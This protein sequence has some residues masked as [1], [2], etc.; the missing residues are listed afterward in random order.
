MTSP[1]S[2]K[3]R[4]FQYISQ[5][6][7]ATVDITTEFGAGGCIWVYLRQLKRDKL[8]KQPKRGMWKRI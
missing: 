3:G 6:Q 8:V 1:L 2:I 5:K 7:R 4:L